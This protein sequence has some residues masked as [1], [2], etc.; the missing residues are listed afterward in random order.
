MDEQP[1]D[2]DLSA[3]RQT[4]PEAVV[5]IKSLQQQLASLEQKMDTLISWTQE[6]TLRSFTRPEPRRERFHEQREPGRERFHEQRDTGDDFRDR[7]FRPAR[8][9]EKFRREENPRFGGPKKSF[10]GGRESGSGSTH[11]FKKKYGGEKR[12]F[13]PRKKPFFRGRPKAENR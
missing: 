4:E 12:D 2:Q 8:N 9:F 11:P 13:S 5:L 10:G 7:S 3:P 1:K 6:E